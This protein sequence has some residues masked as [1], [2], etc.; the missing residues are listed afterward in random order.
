MLWCSL[1]CHYGM[2]AY[3]CCAAP[4]ALP[5]APIVVAIGAK[6]SWVGGGAAENPRN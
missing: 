6:V 2:C 3:S 5:P 4:R 1:A